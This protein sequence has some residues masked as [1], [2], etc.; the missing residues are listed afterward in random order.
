M[1]KQTA[2]AI[3][4]LAKEGSLD[5]DSNFEISEVDRLDKGCDQIIFAIGGLAKLGLTAQQ[6]TQALNTVMEANNAKLGMPRDEHGKLMKP[7][8]FVGPEA[9]LQVILDNRITK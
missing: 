1:A 5:C 2:R 6:I 9:K 4:Q 7:E 8:G 3:T